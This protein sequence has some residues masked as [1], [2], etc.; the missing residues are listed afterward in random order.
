MTVFRSHD[1][2]TR[3]RLSS[4]RIKRLKANRRHRYSSTHT[5]R[6]S[7]KSMNMF[8]LSSVSKRLCGAELRRVGPM[9]MF[10][11]SSAARDLA[12]WC[13]LRRPLRVLS[14]RLAHDA[15]ASWT[16]S[17]RARDARCALPQAYSFITATRR[18]AAGRRSSCLAAVAL[19]KA[20]LRQARYGSHHL[21]SL[22]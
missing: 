11:L 2:L 7:T 16:W 9:I 15:R 4:L 1:S 10:L 8:K 14:R 6:R 12:P 20:T 22:I 17:K 18:Q 5:K 13:L 3:Y 21:H 19:V